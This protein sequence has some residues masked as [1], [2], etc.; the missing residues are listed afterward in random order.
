LASCPD[1][2]YGYGFS[3]NGVATTPLA[4]RI[5][6]SLALDAE[7]EWS[8]CGL[9]RPVDSWMPPEPVKYVGALMVRHA[10]RR[11]D[12]LAYEDREPGPLV[13][14]LAALAPGGIVTTRLER[15]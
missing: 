3:G 15:D 11:K 6:A 14:R 9:V 5:L 1:V 12:A 7:D 13:R 2:L 4:G 8:A 10:V